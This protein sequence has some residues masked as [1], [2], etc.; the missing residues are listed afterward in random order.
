MKKITD[1]NELRL[2]QMDILSYVDKVCRDNNIKYSISG[3]TL[4]GAV[5]H[6]GY[7]P[8][9][10]D[11]DIM[12]AREEYEKLV[13]VMS[14][15]RTDDTYMML[16]HEI[17]KDFKFP[18]A[19]VVDNRTIMHED[20]K[21]CKDYGVYIDI[22]PIDLIPNNDTE[23]EGIFAGMRRL[24]NMLTLKRLKLARNRSLWKNLTITISQIC[25]CLVSNDWIIREME[26]KAKTSARQDSQRR[27]CLVW[28]YGRREIVPASVHQSH[29][30][31]PFEDRTYMA[32][33][34]YHTYLSNLFGDYM[35]LP[36]EEKRVT[37]HGFDAYWKD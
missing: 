31:L 13:T 1:V 19:K 29:I 22:F 36:P 35:Q 17:D 30:D 24:Y 11:I 2:I 18:Y 10:D 33:A 26:K 7:I 4:I 20:V 9:D 15:H 34:D 28:G 27:C 3:G 14:N 23:C 8:W 12:L 6:K 5:R 25:L 32:V 21:G 37:H 16:T